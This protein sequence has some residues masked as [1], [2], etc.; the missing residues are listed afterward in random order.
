VRQECPQSRPEAIFFLPH[1]P[2]RVQDKK[3]AEPEPT[4]VALRRS[5]ND[6]GIFLSSQ[7]PP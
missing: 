7:E 5:R 1:R 3:V 2:P 4:G 6:G